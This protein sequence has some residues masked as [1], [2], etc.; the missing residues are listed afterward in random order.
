[1]SSEG[2]FE[3]FFDF[4]KPP[5]K[6]VMDDENPYL[7][8]KDKGIELISRL[9]PIKKKKKKRSMKKFDHIVDEKLLEHIAYQDSTTENRYRC[10]RTIQCRKIK[11]Y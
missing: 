1:M 9:M 10:R 7:M 6:P 3:D 5:E 2:N 8:E 4:D 11:V